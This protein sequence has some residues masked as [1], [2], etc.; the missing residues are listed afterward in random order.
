MDLGRRFQ[1]KK[2]ALRGCRCRVGELRGKTTF[3][4]FKDAESTSAQHTKVA[5]FIC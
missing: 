3:D 5:S 1:E 4:N 2:K